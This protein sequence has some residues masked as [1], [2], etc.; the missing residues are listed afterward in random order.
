MPRVLFYGLIFSANE[1]LGLQA[2]LELTGDVY[3]KNQV[4]ILCNIFFFFAYFAQSS[5]RSERRLQCTNCP[6]TF[7]VLWGR[8]PASVHFTWCGKIGWCGSPVSDRRWRRHTVGAALTINA[9]RTGVRRV[10][11]CGAISSS[12]PQH[13][14]LHVHSFHKQSTK[15]MPRHGLSASLTLIRLSFICWIDRVERCYDIAE[16]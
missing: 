16:F 5:I 14:Y 12:T 11:G 6:N 7:C 13:T 2:A 4:I 1:W 9:S 8:V 3:D 10:V 15:A